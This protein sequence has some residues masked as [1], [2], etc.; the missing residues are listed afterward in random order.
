MCVCVAYIYIYKY[1]YIYIY[2]YIYGGVQGKTRGLTMIMR[3]NHQPFKNRFRLYG[4]YNH[5]R[6]L[7][8][9]LLTR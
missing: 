8:T 9:H 5:P 6:P 2:I 3:K 4:H 7:I 1:V